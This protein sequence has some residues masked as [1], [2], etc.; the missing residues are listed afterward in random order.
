M[1][2]G[3]LGLVL[4]ETVQSFLLGNEL[5]VTFDQL[6]L[7]RSVLSLGFFQQRF[8][9]TGA[10]GSEPGLFVALVAELF[11]LIVLCLAACIVTASFFSLAQAVCFGFVANFA[12]QTR[13]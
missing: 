12:D 8:D 13:F 6:L 4:L 7:C 1:L 5:A 2:G 10:L 9:F 3:E 11:L